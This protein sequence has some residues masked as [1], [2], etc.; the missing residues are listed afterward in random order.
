[1]NTLD[2]VKATLVFSPNCVMEHA[3]FSLL[4]MFVNFRQWTSGFR[5]EFCVAGCPMRI[6]QPELSTDTFL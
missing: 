6:V 3:R 1:M 5:T 4:D 2:E